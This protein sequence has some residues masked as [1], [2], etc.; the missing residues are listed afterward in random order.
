MLINSKVYKICHLNST[1]NNRFNITF[2][3]FQIKLTLHR[4]VFRK[5]YGD[6]ASL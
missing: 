2:F 4:Q 1:L 5:D 3:P 6:V